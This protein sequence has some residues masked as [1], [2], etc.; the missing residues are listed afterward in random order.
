LINLK[1]ETNEKKRVEILIEL[2]NELLGTESS[3][4]PEY[5]S[6][7]LNISRRSGYK[8]F[9]IQ[10]NKGFAD[11][12]RITDQYNDS[13]QYYQIC[14][15]SISEINDKLLQSHIYEGFANYYKRVA[16]YDTAIIYMQKAIALA[17]ELKNY[18][19]L[20]NIFCNTG[21]IYIEIEEFDQAKEY[22]LKAKKSAEQI[23]NKRIYGTALIG[24]GIVYG[25]KEDLNNAILNFE[26][27]YSIFE[28]L[29]D[30]R[31]MG[32]CLSNLSFAYILKKDFKKAIEIGNKTISYFEKTNGRKDLAD[33]YISLSGIL[34]ESGDTRSAIDY[35]LKGLK[36]AEE[37]KNP[38]SMKYAYSKLAVYYSVMD[39]YRS[40][41][42]YQKKAMKLQS[43]IYTEQKSKQ[44]QEIEAVYQVKAKQKEIEFQDEK[45]RSKDTIIEQQQKINRY[46][47]IGL[48]LISVLAFFALLNY[49]QKRK[50][51]IV[52]LEKNRIIEVKQ[53]EILDSIHYA[54]RIQ[55]T[56]LA[57]SDFIN[58]H[59]PS[60]FI[61]F[62]PKDIVS[63]DFYWATKK[64]HL[65]FLTVCDSTGHGVPGAFMSLLNIGFLSEAINEKGITDPGEIFNFVRN[66]LINS[67]SKEGQKDGFDG[68]LICLNKNTGVITYASANNAPILIR[69]KEIHSLN[70]N[71]M[72]VGIGIKS[73]K[74]ETY[75]LDI[76]KEE[77]LY[78]YTDGYADQFGGPKGKKFM[79]KKLNH[80]LLEI[81][82]KSLPEQKQL[83]EETFEEWRGNL[84][85]VDDVAI[86][87]IRFKM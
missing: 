44:L 49:I 30:T 63:G 61:L 38:E 19:S 84:E 78:L 77:T 56:L 34:N 48:S 27:A 24:L 64:D 33:S 86:I 8:K 26:K 21:S 11:Y 1:Q 81:S 65:F 74:F 29:K 39:D 7:A 46:T 50:A 43:E 71:K 35:A 10:A 52:L 54:K 28:E 37:I 18:G 62:K 51:N 31:L 22:Y 75:T 69:N 41:F 73:E 15:R 23:N 3:K 42:D 45:I 14:L 60:N 4:S 53:K 47:I 76:N 70:Y 2:G 80:L 82:D 79:Y 40:A 83:L 9:E 6:E 36:I 25:S 87:G 68:I 20:G 13:R 32:T 12:Y 55:T 59:L 67:I 16:I 85:Q 57:H 66:R 5:F 17:E 58:E 72:P